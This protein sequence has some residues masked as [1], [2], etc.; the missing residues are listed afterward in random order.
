MG[1]V[2]VDIW[3]QAD[4]RSVVFPNHKLHHFSHSMAVIGVAKA[5]VVLLLIVNKFY[6]LAGIYFPAS[7]QPTNSKKHE[8][9]L[10]VFN[11]FYFVD[12]L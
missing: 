4:M 11:S 12:F 10:F 3:I 7:N 1:L 2:P 8:G 9:H 6:Q 5:A